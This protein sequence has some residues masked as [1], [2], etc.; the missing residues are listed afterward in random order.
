MEESRPFEILVRNK[1]IDKGYIATLTDLQEQHNGDIWVTNPTKQE[2]FYVECKADR[3]IY[4]T[5]NLYIETELIRAGQRSRGWIDYDYEI[6]A[7]I[8]ASPA[9][10]NSTA[11]K[12]IYLID[13]PKLKAQIGIN[14]SKCRKITHKL[15]D[16]VSCGLLVPLQYIKDNGCLLDVMYYD[17]NDWHKVKKELMTNN[18]KRNITSGKSA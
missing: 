10:I 15:D 1:F 18:D 13:F 4:R 9:R 17:S 11:R 6:V 2:S 12:A 16:L 5:G 8:D 3:N 7:V 14:D